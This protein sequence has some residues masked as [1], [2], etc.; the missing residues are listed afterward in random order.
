MLVMAEVTISKLRKIYGA[1]EVIHGVDLDIE[2]GEFVISS[3][4]RA[5]ESPRCCG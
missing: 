1:V 5:A 2:D 4:L 3:G